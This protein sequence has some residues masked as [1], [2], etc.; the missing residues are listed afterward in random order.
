MSEVK[1]VWW[2]K[3]YFQSEKYTSRRNVLVKIVP[4]KC[5]RPVVFREKVVLEICS[6]FKGEHPC[7]SAISIKLL[8][9]FIEITLRLGRSPEN[10]QH[11]FQPLF[12]KNTP[13]WLLLS[14]VWCNKLKKTSKKITNKIN[15]KFTMGTG[16][17]PAGKLAPGKLAP[18]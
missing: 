10:L 2:H 15:L 14:M 8:Y 11:I 4:R 17:W 5:S 16:Q 18:G 12:P 1:V 13:G 6:K 3:K 9:N 7:R